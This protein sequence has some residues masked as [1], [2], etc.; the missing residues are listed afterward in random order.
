MRHSR[1]TTLPI[2]LA[3]SLVVSNACSVPF[4]ALTAAADVTA[5]PASI[6]VAS[7]PALTIGQTTK[8]TTVVKDAE[9]RVL[10]DASVAWGNSAPAVASII[11]DGTVTALS[12]GTVTFTAA[13]GEAQASV[14]ITVSPASGAP[15]T[16]PP[17]TPP[18]STTPSSAQLPTATVETAMPDAPAAGGSI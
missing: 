5:R 8:L 12:A 11:A 4:D 3:L 10:T 1:R 13:S 16:T 6:V 18:P 15:P 9:G 17:T 2:I 7:V 14:T